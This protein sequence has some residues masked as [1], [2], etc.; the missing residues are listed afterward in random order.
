M[1]LFNRRE[2]FTALNTELLFRVR[3]ALAEA[4]LA[5]TVRTAGLMDAAASRG[6]GVPGIRQD[7]LY[8]Y[9]IYVHKQDYDRAYAVLQACLRKG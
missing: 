6:R 4:G 1:T 9:Q 3:N 7:H 5:S 8:Q 2:L